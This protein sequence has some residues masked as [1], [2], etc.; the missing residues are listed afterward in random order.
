VSA[1]ALTPAHASSL[2]AADYVRKP[3]DIGEFIDVVQRFAPCS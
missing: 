2:G 1:E 3:F